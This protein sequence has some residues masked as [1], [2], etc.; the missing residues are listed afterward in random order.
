MNEV[1]RIA[2]KAMLKVRLAREVLHVGVHFPG[3][4][5]G[6]IAQV[7]KVLQHQA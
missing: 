5:Q 2:E 1:A 7:V 4:T 6:L 3:F